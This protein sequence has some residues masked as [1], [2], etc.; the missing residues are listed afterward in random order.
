MSTSNGARPG[1]PPGTGASST[2]SC[3]TDGHHL[4]S[5]HGFR[6]QVHRIRALGPRALG[7]PL[8]EVGR[9]PAGMRR[10]VKRYAELDP[11]LVEAVGGRDWI[12]YRDFV[13]EVL[14]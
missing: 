10:H 6:Q 5:D 9:D 2:S 14:P 7:E 3:L 12:D 1:G 13:R 8:L 4:T 11:T